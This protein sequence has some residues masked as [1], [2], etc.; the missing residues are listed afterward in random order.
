MNTINPYIVGILSSISATIITSAVW[1]GWRRIKEI[2]KLFSFLKVSP[3]H[4]IILI[5]GNIHKDQIEED[6]NQKRKNYATFEYGD[7]S[8]TLAI[9]D[10]LK[11]P[12]KNNL[13]HTVGYSPTNHLQGNL[14]SVGGPKWNKTTERF[15][16]QVGSPLLFKSEGLGAI[17]KRKSHHNEN[18]HEPT[19]E[20]RDGGRLLISDYGVVIC[21]R[22]SYLGPVVPLAIVIAGYST[23][24]VM[25]AAEFFV[26]IPKREIKRLSK[27]FN[28]DRRFGI[29]VKGNLE[30]D[31]LGQ[32]IS[33][34]KIDIVS[35]IPEKD[36]LDPF[37]YHY[38]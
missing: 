6:S 33:I 37:D 32:V 10:R 23:Y 20:K 21:A 16:G 12:D 19:S 5:H 11:I 4:D 2:D 24:G 38:K 22:S 8:A 1:Y 9:Y 18:C 30:I 34:N 29:L 3:G 17:E 25:I 14:I 36:F 13:K 15:L 35:E 27:R 31:L 7:I 26:N 28:G